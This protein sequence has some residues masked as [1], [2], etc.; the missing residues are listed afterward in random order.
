MKSIDREIH[1]NIFYEDEK[2]LAFLDNEPN[3]PGHS[4]VIPKKPFVNVFDIDE[5]TW[6]AVMR[7]VRKLAPVI[8]DAVGADGVN[9]NSNHGEYAG[10]KI[11]HLHIHIIPRFKEDGLKFTWPEIPLNANEAQTLIE[12]IRAQL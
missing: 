6:L 3:T 7:T 5:D 8:R 4:L 9:I 12:K 2:T 1:A 10:Q 11:S